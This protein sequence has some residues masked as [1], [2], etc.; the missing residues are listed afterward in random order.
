MAEIYE[1]FVKDCQNIDLSE[2]AAYQ[3]YRYETFG[4]I[5]PNN[6]IINGY[7]LGKKWMDI[8][9][10]MWKEDLLCK[11]LFVFELQ[12]DGYPDWF[13]ERVGIL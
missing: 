12:E 8:T 1:K 3:M 5:I 13:L 9:I 10:S 6:S 7:E 11:N 4:G 2:E